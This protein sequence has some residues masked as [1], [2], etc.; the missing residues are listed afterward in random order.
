[1]RDCGPVSWFLGI[2]VIRNRPERKIYLCQDAYIER[3]VHSLKHRRRT[4]IRYHRIATC[5]LLLER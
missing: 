1:M 5:L 3:M 4:I 2:R